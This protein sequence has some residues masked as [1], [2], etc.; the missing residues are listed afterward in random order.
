[1]KNN[2]L[3]NP[4]K[5]LSIKLPSISKDNSPCWHVEAQSKCLCGKQSFDES[6]REEDFDG[7]L[8]NGEETRVMDANPSLQQGQKMNH[9]DWY[10]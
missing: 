9:L 10:S 8:E 3:T 1:M 2:N 7:L 4:S 5:V 6:L